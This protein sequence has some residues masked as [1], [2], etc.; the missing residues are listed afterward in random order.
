MISRRRLE[1]LR[2]CGERLH[3]QRS[4]VSTVPTPSEQNYCAHET[5]SELHYGQSLGTASPSDQSRPRWDAVGQARA[6]NIRHCSSVGPTRVV[7]R[8]KTDGSIVISRSFKHCAHL[9]LTSI[10]SSN[11]PLTEQSQGRLVSRTLIESSNPGSPAQWKVTAQHLSS[12][13]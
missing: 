7:N 11:R 8:F 13:H 10:L 4:E 9:F 3:G 6:I 1:C 12:E 5:L 2:L